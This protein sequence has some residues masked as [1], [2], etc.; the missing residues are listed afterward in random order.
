V[1]VVFAGTTWFLHKTTSIH[2]SVSG[3]AVLGALFAFTYS[4]WTFLTEIFP[5][6]S[7]PGGILWIFVATIKLVAAYLI[8]FVVGPI[9]IARTIN[10]IWLT[11]RLKQRITRAQALI[12]N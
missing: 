3:S 1:A 6:T 4:G 12:A 8:G 10:D 5:L 9:Q 7:L 11:G 2:L